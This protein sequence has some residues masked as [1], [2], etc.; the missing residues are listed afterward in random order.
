LKAV[1]S[2]KEAMPQDAF[3][4]LCRC[5]H[6]ADDWEDDGERWSEKYHHVKEEPS[7]ETATHQRKF[8]ILEDGYNK[9]W[10]A[11]VNFGRCVTADES[12]AAGWYH[13]P[14][15][16]G[17]EPKPIQTGATLHSLCVSYGDLATYKLFV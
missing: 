15:T 8:S 7:E 2:I 16:L 5:M 13:S 11:I 10:Q 17:P 12:R 1:S 4:D 3:K 9:R 14:M 6:F